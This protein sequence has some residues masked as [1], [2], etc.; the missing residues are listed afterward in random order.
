MFCE[1]GPTTAE[2]VLPQWIRSVMDPVPTT[3]TRLEQV[4]T[5]QS[6]TETEKPVSSDERAAAAQPTASRTP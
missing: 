5:G 1:G 3:Y 4:G 6:Y 2:H